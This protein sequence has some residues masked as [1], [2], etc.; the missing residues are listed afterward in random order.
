MN[1]DESKIPFQILERISNRFVNEVVSFSSVVYDITSKTPETINW[2]SSNS[3]TRCFLF[4]FIANE[5]SKKNS[6]QS[7]ITDG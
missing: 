4:T 2:N 3:I 5:K 6:S 1:A 7:N